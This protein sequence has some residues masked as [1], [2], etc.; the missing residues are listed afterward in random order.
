MTTFVRATGVR[1]PD[2]DI[3][4]GQPSWNRQ[5]TTSMPIGRYTP[6]TPI[7]LPDRSWPSTVITKAPLWCA[8]D[9][10]DGNQALIDPM[11][12]PRKRRLFDLLVEMGYKEIEVGFPA[13]SQ[14]D[15]DFV[16]EIIEQDAIPDDVRIQVLTQARSGADRP[17]LRGCRGRAFRRRPPVQ[18]DLDAAA[19]GRVRPADERHHPDRDRRRRGGAAL[20]GQV[21]GH[22]LA[23]RVLP[24][25]LHRHRTGIRGRGLQLGVGDLA[26]D[27]R[28]A[29][30]R[31]PARHRRDGH[32]ERLRRLHR[33]D[34]PQPA[35]PRLDR[36]VAAPAQRPGHRRRGR[37]TRVHGRRGPD[38]GVPVRQRRAHRQ[39]L[40]GDPGAQPVQPGHRPAD[41]LLRHRRDP[42]HRRVRQRAEGA[43]KAS[44]RWRSRV[45]G[46][47]RIAPGR[48][49]EGLRPPA[50]RRGGGRRRRWTNSPGR[51]PTCRSTRTTSG[52]RTRP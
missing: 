41:R 30:G 34:A 9:L 43:R 50:P 4:A 10:R 13:A 32:P 19:P 38:R 12:P 52:D 3:P 26:A 14:T 15:F 47:L 5:R 21:P 24:G 36:A 1:R 28:P 51:C 31:Q 16:R 20:G 18:L 7:D 40:P 39:R 2:G 22:R 8:V 17:H 35:A 44:L 23:L 25:V 49:Q 6:F 46:V 27:P 11:T 37:R 45:H 29:D 48:D 33:M 42:P